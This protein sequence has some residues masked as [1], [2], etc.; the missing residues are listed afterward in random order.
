[1]NQHEST[2]T[3][4]EKVPANQQSHT[5]EEP[6]IETV[7]VDNYAFYH[8]WY[9]A[10]LY[11]LLD[12]YTFKGKDYTALAQQLTPHITATQAQESIQLLLRLGY[13]Y[14]DTDGVYHNAEMFL[15]AGSPWKSEVISTYQKNLIRLVENAVDTQ[16]KS[17]RDISTMTVSIARTDVSKMKNLIQQFQRDTLKLAQQSQESDSVYQMNVQLFPLTQ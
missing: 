5:L 14:I 13:L 10:A 15:G 3:P 12:F 8:T 11:T 2:Q 4:E 16:E 17:D 9:H 6:H 1:M 7:S